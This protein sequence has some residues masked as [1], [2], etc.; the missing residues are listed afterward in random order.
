[1]LGDVSVV[2]SS[3]DL[4]SIDALDAGLTGELISYVHYE[5]A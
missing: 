1:M 3:G 4:E 2:A 5:T